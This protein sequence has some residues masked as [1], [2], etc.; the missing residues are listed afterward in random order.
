MTL[1]EDQ[2]VFWRR[3]DGAN[4]SEPRA[5]S[6][7]IFQSKQITAEAPKISPERR[8]TIS[9]EAIERV[10]ELAPGWDKY[11]LESTYLNWAKDKEPARNEDAR[12]LGWVKSFT[13]GKPP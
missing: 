7:P 13:K 1:E 4:A 11:Y 5:Q 2:V 10:P 9:A 3:G 6:P 8:I 12:F